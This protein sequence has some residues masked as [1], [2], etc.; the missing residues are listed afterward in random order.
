MFSVFHSILSR[1]TV[2]FRLCVIPE[3]RLTIGKKQRKQEMEDGHY[4]WTNLTG[5]RCLCERKD[6]AG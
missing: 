1:I 4:K 2:R 6:L 3:A 5:E